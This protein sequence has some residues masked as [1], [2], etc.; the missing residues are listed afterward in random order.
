MERALAQLQL[1]RKPQPFARLE[2]PATAGD[3]ITRFSEADRETSI[4]AFAAAAAA[5]RCMQFTPA[6]GAAT[7]MFK[8]LLAVLGR[9]APT[10]LAEL[11]KQ[12]S[13]GDADAKETLV[14]W[15][16]LPHFAFRSD[17]SEVLARRG[18]DLAA[19]EAA[20]DYRPVLEALLRRESV[21]GLEGLEYADRPKALIAF[22]RAPA[23]SPDGEPHAALDEHLAEAA[24]LV[25]DAGGIC[26]IHF[27]VSPDH[28]NAVV[29][30]LERVRARF[31]KA[32][33]R[34]EI[35]LSFQ[36]SATNTLAADADN[37]PF[38]D[39]DGDL[40]FRPAG[41]GALL[42]NLHQTGGDIAFLR[43]IDNT[44]PEG[45]AREH[46]LAWRRALGGHLVALQS[47]AFAHLAR[48]REG[49]DGAPIEA[50]TRFLSAHLGTRLPDNLAAPT[51]DDQT[52]EDQRAYL[53]QSL[54]RPLRVCAMVKNQGEPGGGPFW[55]R[56]KDGSLRLQI[57]ES[58]QVDPSDPAQREIAAAATHFNPVD[59][60]CA[61]RDHQGRLHT[62]KDHID[63]DTYFITTKSKDGKPIKAL[64]LPGLWNGSMALWNTAFVEVPVEIFNPV[65]TVNDLLRPSHRTGA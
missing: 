25:R 7:R 40:V 20:G 26:R 39:K 30:R 8:G 15:K 17:L 23:T 50:A 55:L 32:G 11:E 44:L 57:V 19:L 22:H 52:L 2:K 60:V 1:F 58:S 12:A 21:E 54:D 29:A 5:G 33:T 18:L 3:G 13:L 31:E 48:L 62:L 4:R 65:K 51:R 59:I 47:Q 53:I 42:E 37:A 28:E 24:A 61:L 38:R 10:P 41:H 27:T 56:H 36:K 14:F 9:A 43:N 35:G 49:V 45:P 34:L 63:P 6:S 46:A 16:G 64:E